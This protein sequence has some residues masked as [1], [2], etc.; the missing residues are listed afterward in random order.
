EAASAVMAD[1]P[2]MVEAAMAGMEPALMAAEAGMVEIGPAMEEVRMALERARIEHGLQDRQDC[3]EEDELRLAALSAL[4]EMDDDRAL[5]ILREVLADRE[6]CAA[7]RRLALMIIAESDSEAAGELLLDVARNDPDPEVRAQ[8]VFWLSEV[9]S[10]Q[11]VDVLGELLRTSDDPTLQERALFALAEHDSPRAG[12]MLRDY[13]QREDV[14]MQLRANAIFWLGERG[15]AQDVELLRRLF[16]EATSPEI[17]QRILFAVAESDDPAGAAWLMEV[18]L[19]TSLDTDT[20]KQALFWASEAGAPIDQLVQLYD[21][22]ADHQMKE[23]LIFVYAERD[24]PAAIDKLLEVARTEQD[25]ELRRRAIF[26]LTESDDPR[27]VDLLLEI[28]R[29]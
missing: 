29:R 12:Q 4:M 19:D 9:D 8:A 17:R 23:Q 6:G 28:L 25:P 14:P 16:A 15:E 21:R 22:A 18:A 20:R 1:V 2:A 3:T 13:A 26:W 27:V 11:A 5:P 7:V 24:E 10:E